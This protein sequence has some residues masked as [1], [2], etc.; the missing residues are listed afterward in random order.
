MNAR[1][2]SSSLRSHEHDV[3]AQRF[4]EHA[5]RV[6]AG[7]VAVDQNLEHHKRVETA[8]AAASVVVRKDRLK[9]HLVDRC[10]DNSDEVVLGDQFICP[11]R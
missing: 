6:S 4:G 2:F 1:S 11:R 9:I 10:A 3:F 7:H 5:R 8:R